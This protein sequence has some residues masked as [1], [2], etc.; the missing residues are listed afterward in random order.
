MREC[1]SPPSGLEEHG[2]VRDVPV[3]VVPSHDNSDILYIPRDSDFE[4]QVSIYLTEL[5]IPD[6]TFSL[7]R[8]KL[9]ISESDKQTDVAEDKKVNMLFVSICF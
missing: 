2:A 6:A 1:V 3:I 8:S 7:S 5:G 4:D 9:D